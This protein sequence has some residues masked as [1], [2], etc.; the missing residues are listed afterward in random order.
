MNTYQ[1]ESF[2]HYDSYGG[3]SPAW[4]RMARELEAAEDFAEYHPEAAAAYAVAI[5][6]LAMIG[7]AVMGILTLAGVIN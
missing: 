3:A 4:L 1:Q 2:E 7:C 5:L 6:T